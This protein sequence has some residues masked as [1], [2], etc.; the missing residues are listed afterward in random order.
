MIQKIKNALI[1]V[2]DKTDLSSVLKVL[3]KYEINIISS[4]GTYTTIKNLGYKCTEVSKYTGFKEMLDGRVKTLHP[5]IHAGILHDRSN[6]KHNN[7]MIKQRF[8]SLDLIVVNFYPFQKII[9]STNNSKKIIENIDIGGPTM[10]RAAAK[11]FKNVLIVTNINDYKDL[12]FEIEKHKGK[13]SL[14]FREFMSSKAFGLTAYYDSMIAQWFNNKLNIKFPEKKTIFG[15]KLKK[16]RYG[17]NPHQ[18][19]SIYINDLNDRETGLISLGGKDLS[20]NNYNDIYASLDILTTL[21]DNPS[22]V[23]TKHANPCGVSSN[24]SPL[25]SFKNAFASDPV[26]AFGGVIA[27]NYKINKS[28]AKEISKNFLEVILAKGFDK[29][30]LKILRKKSNLRIINISKY[31]QKNN[32]VS[33]TFHNSFLLQEKDLSI[34]NYK[35]LKF[36]TKKKPTKNELKEI[37]FAFNICKFVKSNAIILTNNFSTIGIGAGQPSRLDSC[38]I[39]TQKAKNFQPSKIKYSIAASDAFFPFADGIK[40]LVNSGVKIIVQPGGSIRDQ[41]VINAA[42]KANIKMIFTGKRHFNH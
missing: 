28:I 4:G 27:C 11:N 13:T 9:T 36:V 8:P 41:E 35:E 42:N 12:L 29:D 20:Y 22:T 7:E 17:E 32:T 6:K 18:K 38:K 39:A 40:I 16:L 31:K 24:K 37:E 2:S 23:I 26:S 15:R 21:K 1:S 25:Q 33:R 30:S 19:S 5:K 3:K 14:A 10:V 34:F